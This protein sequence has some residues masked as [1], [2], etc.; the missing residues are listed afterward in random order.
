MIKKFIIERR[1]WILLFI[2]FQLLYLFVTYIDAAIPLKPILYMIF[3]SSIIFIVFLFVRYHKETRF[4]R[5]LEDWDHSLDTTNISEAE[6]P[7]EKIIAD[8]LINQTNI[9]KQETLENWHTLEREKDEL[10]SWIH[11]VK[12]P[13]S[14]MNLIMD[15]LE[16]DKIKAQLTYEWLRIHHLLDQQL[17]QKRLPFI[18]NDLFIER[19]DLKAVIFQ[20][21]KA[22]QPWCMQK[23]IGFDVDFQ[24]TEVLSDPKWLGFITRQFLTNAIKYSNES[25]ILLKSY[26][27]NGQVLLQIQ[28]FGR[29]IDPKDLPRIF[30]QGFT[31]TTEHHDGRATGM[32]LFLAK[33]AAQPLLITIEVMSEIGAGTTFTL[34]FPK[35]NDFVHI[36]G[37]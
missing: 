16:D 6:T 11:E 4:I 3:L 22:L 20:E 36:S 21:I 19:T 33:K 12:T 31:S 17:H 14:A 26:Q 29:G 25:D 5:S 18:Q 27:H 34:A 9:L 35:R 7:F 30:D 32:G 37:M 8:R 24:V 13:L 28:D 2:V 1:S 10:L 15:R 23:G